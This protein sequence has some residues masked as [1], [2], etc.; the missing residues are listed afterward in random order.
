[1]IET[2]FSRLPKYDH[3]SRF[4][5]RLLL[6]AWATWTRFAHGKLPILMLRKRC[7]GVLRKL[8]AKSL[9]RSLQQYGAVYRCDAHKQS[10]VFVGANEKGHEQAH[11]G[12]EGGDT[13]PT[14]ERNI[15]A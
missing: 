1:L 2:H 5:N 15:D 11:A 14:K 9:E 6:P 13:S 4:A 8:Q 3:L 10:S 12:V 7:G